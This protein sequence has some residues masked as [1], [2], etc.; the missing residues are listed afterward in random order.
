[1]DVPNPAL[2]KCNFK[3]LE[4]SQIE[5]GPNVN[6]KVGV[7]ANL[8]MKTLGAVYGDGEGGTLLGSG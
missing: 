2:S 8:F 1:M 5:S 7:D 3:A 6:Q 4:F